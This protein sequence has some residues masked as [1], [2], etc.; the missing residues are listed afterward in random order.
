MAARYAG[1]LLLYT[2]YT[3]T[4]RGAMAHGPFSCFSTVFSMSNNVALSLFLGNQH[5]EQDLVVHVNWARQ[6]RMEA[7]Y[8]T[9]IALINMSAIWSHKI[10][11]GVENNIWLQ[12]FYDHVVNFSK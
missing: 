6:A 5:V 3:L 2:L 7:I 11:A 10:H 1:H 12:M 8:R 9:A 4:A